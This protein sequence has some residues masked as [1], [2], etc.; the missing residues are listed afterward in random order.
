MAK[1]AIS[2]A[3]T[4]AAAIN[5][6][7]FRDHQRHAAKCLARSMTPEQRSE[8]ARKAAKARHAKAR[9]KK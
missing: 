7:A 5:P 8:R 9:G 2:Q 3:F 1:S 4:T 6:K